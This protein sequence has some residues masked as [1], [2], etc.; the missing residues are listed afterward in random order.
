MSVPDQAD[1]VRHFFGPYRTV[2]LLNANAQ[3]CSEHAYAMPLAVKSIGR[4]L[5]ET[6]ESMTDLIDKNARFKK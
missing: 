6:K 4:K 2:C 3:L 1:E 5:A